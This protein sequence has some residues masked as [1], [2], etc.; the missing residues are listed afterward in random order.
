MTQPRTASDR[1]ARRKAEAS[2]GVPQPP[3]GPFCNPLSPLELLD[4]DQLQR[5]DDTAFRILEELG[6]EFM[7]AEALD[8]L[9]RH[10]AAVDRATGLVRFDR[11]LVREYVAKAPASFTVY[12]RNPERNV[13]MGGNF[14]NF[15]PVGGAPNVSDLERGRRPGTYRDQVEL[16]KLHQSLTCLHLTGGIQ[17]EAQDL[18]VPT[19]HL[20]LHVAHATLTD[21]VWNGRPI[22]RQRIADAIEIARLARGI[23]REQML[24]E[25]SLL[26]IINTNS[27]RRVDKELLGGLM[28]MAENGQAVCVTPFTLAGA[29]SPITLAG[30]LAQQSAEALGV[31]AFTQMVKPGAPAIFGG[32]TSN[33]D[34]KTG[35]PAFGTPEYVRATL[36]GGQLAR[37][38][39]LPYRASNVTASPA[40]DAQA[41]WEAA[42]SL[43]A[44]VMAHTNWVHHATGWLEGGLTASFEKVILD[45]EMIMT[46]RAWLAPFDMGE[47]DLAFEAIRD[48]PPGGHFFGT[49]HTLARFEHAFHKPLIAEVRNYDAWVEAGSRTATE[50]A[51][52]VWK[53][54]LD[55]FTPPPL[56]AGRLEAIN[57]YV[58]RRRREIAE[59]GLGGVM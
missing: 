34:M 54:L 19:R 52:G 35:A 50:R 17:V 57:D 1:R 16:L 20:D 55:H 41:T 18:P 51:A 12:A 45:A 39:K 37:R 15:G 9:A 22:G 8:V 6:L 40:S 11:A 2:A 49:A 30:A 13:T 4:E 21:R 27:P 47:D 31:I 46:M 44:C 5:L 58:A 23:S 28:E 38:W 24:R 42:M 32:F 43:W 29:M 56:D 59:K 36:V 25:P 48:V 14:I 26:T 3:W 53:R 33:V 7:S 10:G